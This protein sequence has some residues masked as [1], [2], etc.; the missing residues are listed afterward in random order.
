MKK[1]S[2]AEK[3]KQ[4]RRQFVERHFK[5]D[6]NSAEI[7]LNGFRHLYTYFDVYWL[8]YGHAI[9]PQRLKQML[10]NVCHEPESTARSHI[11]ALV[12]EDN[13]LFFYDKE[14]DVLYLDPY[15]T[16]EFLEELK[17]LLSGH[18]DWKYEKPEDAY[19]K[20]KWARAEDTDKY[21]DEAYGIE[22]ETKTNQS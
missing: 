14:Q 13:G 21:W 11:K 16:D 20:G 5:G 4:R 12:E 10:M 6:E 2:N 7:L 18:G 22:D 9:R 3:Q 8:T 15:Y 19:T 1:K 17:Y